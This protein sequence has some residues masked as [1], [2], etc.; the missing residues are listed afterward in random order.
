MAMGRGVLVELY[1]IDSGAFSAAKFVKQIRD[2]NQRS[3]YCCGPTLITR[4]GWLNV[5]SRTHLIRLV[6]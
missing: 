6:L 2:D 3:R 4:T 1:L 5:A